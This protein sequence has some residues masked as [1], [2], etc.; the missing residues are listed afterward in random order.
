MTFSFSAFA[1]ESSYDETYD[2]SDL[3]YFYWDLSYA[4]YKAYAEY[5]KVLAAV[6]PL[7]E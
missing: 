6:S 2:E 1:E 4:S 3:V 5:N 7:Y